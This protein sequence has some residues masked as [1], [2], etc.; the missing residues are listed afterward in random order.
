MGSSTLLTITRDVLAADEGIKA[1][2]QDKYS[3]DPLVIL[4]ND[5]EDPPTQADYPVIIIFAVDR[6]ERGESEKTLRYNLEIG[7]GV[8]NSTID[9]ATL[10]KKTYPGKVEAEELRELVEDALFKRQG[11]TGLNASLDIVGGTQSDVDFP[12]F[13]SD[14]IIEIKQNRTSRNPLGR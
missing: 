9:T 3:K 5:E 2:T 11:A 14:T 6:A 13:R 4:G 8:V 12:I 7:V 10:G 1:Y